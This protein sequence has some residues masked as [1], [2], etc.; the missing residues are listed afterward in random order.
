MN[1][2]ASTLQSGQ[3][4]LGSRRGCFTSP[5]ARHASLYVLILSKML[6]TEDGTS[7]RWSEFLTSG[8][9]AYQP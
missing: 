8:M 6:R 2:R 9:L 7:Y 1:F 5:A 4:S 3:D